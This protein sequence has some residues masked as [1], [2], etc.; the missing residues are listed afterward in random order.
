MEARVANRPT[1]MPFRVLLIDDDERI[2][3]LLSH[4]LSLPGLEFHAASDGASGADAVL[5]L[6]PHLVLLDLGL[7]DIDG[8]TL[9]DQLL[10]QNPNL[11][12]IVFSGLHSNHTAVEAIQKGASD[13]IT[14]PASLERLLALVR[15]RVQH[16]AL[17]EPSAE[18]DFDAFRE[19]DGIIGRSPALV[20]VLGKIE[21]IGPHFRTALISGETGTGKD[22]AARALHRTSQA[23]GP[24]VVCNCA[25]MVET[26]F[27]S[28]LFGYQKGAFTG[29]THDKIGLIEHANGGTLFLDEIGELPLTTQ[30]KLLRVL[31][32]REVQ[33]IGSATSRPVNLRVIGATNRNLREMV[34]NREFREDLYFRLALLEIA[35][36]RLTE[37]I[38][39][40]PL[41]AN[42][43]LDKFSNIFEAPRQRLSRR[44][45]MLLSKHTWPGNIREL[46]NV[47]TYCCMMSRSEVIDAIDLPPYLHGTPALPETPDQLLSME[48]MRLQYVKTV[49]ERTGGNQSRAAHILGIGRSTLR[50][51]LKSP[52]A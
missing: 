51:Y 30:A 47:I 15:Q 35:M 44:V 33:R 40:L 13:Y 52:A 22:L 37:R 28:E 11:D 20:T 27:E 39:D 38:E 21:R 5:T 10:E 8:L 7:P 24:F 18:A 29:A 45:Q 23:P 3:D 17:I 46:E 26:L 36:P 25:A 32:T 9:L 1:N 6:H 12:V 2:A 31:Q 50:R 4:A 14:K 42:Y 48:T 19:R 16:E 49:L 34:A 43:F 41:L